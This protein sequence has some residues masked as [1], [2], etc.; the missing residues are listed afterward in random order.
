ME[1]L[2]N[3]DPAVCALSTESVISSFI[4]S[5]YSRGDE[6]IEMLGAGYITKS[7]SS[8][9]QNQGFYETTRENSVEPFTCI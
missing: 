4:D 5:F 8:M 9:Q 6:Q 1:A 2:L 7:Q 3:R